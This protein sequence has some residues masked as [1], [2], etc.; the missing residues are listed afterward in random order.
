M[1]KRIWDK[2]REKIYCEKKCKKN[3]LKQKKKKCEYCEKEYRIKT[4]KQK[5]CSKECNLKNINENKK[6]NKVRK[7]KKCE[8]CKKSFISKNKKQKL[9]GIECAKE[10]NRRDKKE[11]INRGRK[12]GLISAGKQQR[13]SKGE[14]YLSELCEEYFGKENIKCNERKFKDKKNNLWD[15]DIIIENIKLAILYNGIWHYKKI[16]KKH[17]LKQ[18]KMRDKL[19]EKIII[20]NNYNY[21]I[22]KDLGSYNKKFVEEEF[23]KLIKYISIN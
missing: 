19:K 18:V 7:E 8:N 13:R 3:V 12:G 23:K 21:Y 22:I 17:K 15:A 20:E 4:E 11:I 10:Y 5:F 6:G 16:N 2:N 9:C 14:K 1:W